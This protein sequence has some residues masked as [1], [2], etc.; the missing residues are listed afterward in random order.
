MSE[1]DDESDILDSQIM[2]R[3]SNF[4]LVLPSGACIGHRSMQHYYEQ[5]I[6]T[7]CAA[8]DPKSATAIV[9]WLLADK[10]S[11]LV[12]MKGGLVHPGRG[13]RRSRGAT[14]ARYG[15][16]ATILESSAE[17]GL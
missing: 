12:P 16:L 2:S 13:C 9:W 17:G 6:P 7:S 8:D 5:S 3:D 14:V 11:D 4:E 10:R 15:R 1:E